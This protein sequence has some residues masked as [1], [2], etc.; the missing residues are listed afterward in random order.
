[1]DLGAAGGVQEDIA[2]ILTY[3]GVDIFGIEAHTFALQSR[4]E[5]V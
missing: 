3:L 2:E 4:S 1:M 5:S